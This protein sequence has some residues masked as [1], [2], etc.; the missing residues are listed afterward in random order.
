MLSKNSLAKK[1]WSQ[2]DSHKANRLQV[3]DV[4]LKFQLFNPVSKPKTTKEDSKGVE[5][6]TLYAEVSFDIALKVL[7]MFPNF[8]IQNIDSSLSFIDIAIL[9]A[10]LYSAYSDDIRGR[11]VDILF[12]AFNEELKL[13]PETAEEKALKRSKLQK[14]QD[15]EAYVSKRL[16]LIQP[17]LEKLLKLLL[18]SKQRPTESLKDKT[19]WG[20]LTNGNSNDLSAIRK[21]VAYTNIS[22][23]VALDVIVKLADETK[24]KIQVKDEVIEEKAKKKEVKKVDESKNKKSKSKETKETKEE[25]KG[26]ES[27]EDE[28][29]KVPQKKE[30]FSPNRTIWRKVFEDYLARFQKHPDG[31]VRS[32]AYYVV[33]SKPIIS[34]G[35]VKK[36]VAKVK[37][38]DVKNKKRR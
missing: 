33:T 25:I 27:K 19:P 28:E 15:D 4:I 20:W 7:E 24:L 1:P 22:A 16:A 26:E 37:V 6:K 23:L 12:N 17:Q 14:I 30:E 2:G 13:L 10:V 29:Q 21:S 18:D 32:Q 38:E 9:R 3:I 31:Q 35:T 5:R 36:K 11:L 8:I 34:V